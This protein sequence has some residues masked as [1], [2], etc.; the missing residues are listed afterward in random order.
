M[1]SNV[2]VIMDAS[3]HN[4]LIDASVVTLL[5]AYTLL[6]SQWWM[7]RVHHISTADNIGSRCVT[8]GGRGNLT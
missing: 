2:H 6:G 4:K 8:P 5:L 3:S 1:T 7:S